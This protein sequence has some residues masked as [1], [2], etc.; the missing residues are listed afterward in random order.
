MSSLI[1]FNHHRGHMACMHRMQNMN[2]IISKQCRCI[3]FTDQS[4]FQC[5][6]FFAGSLAVDDDAGSAMMIYRGKTKIV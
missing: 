1:P 6:P 3:K 2:G 4:F 5:L